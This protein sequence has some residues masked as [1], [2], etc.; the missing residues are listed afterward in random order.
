M[1]F[2]VALG[3]LKVISGG[4][5]KGTTK[6]EKERRPMTTNKENGTVSAPLAFP[7][8]YLVVLA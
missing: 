8:P 3:L 7:T 5:K 6:W 4:K 2:W 1:V